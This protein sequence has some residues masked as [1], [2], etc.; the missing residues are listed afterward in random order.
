MIVWT[1][2]PSPG[3]FRRFWPMPSE[4]PKA[5]SI[6]DCKRRVA[7]MIRL[8]HAL[9]RS[10]FLRLQ[11]RARQS[12]IPNPEFPFLIPYPIP[13]PHPHPPFSSPKKIPKG[14]VA[15]WRSDVRE[16]IGEIPETFFSFHFFISGS[17][18]RILETPLLPY[19]TLQLRSTKFYA[20]HYHRYDREKHSSTS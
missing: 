1:C 12:P 5:Q 16:L 7:P 6:A 13:I 14:H 18:S 4:S 11:L 3:G 15:H 8:R 19:I 20:D 9:R 17:F 10:T 2:G